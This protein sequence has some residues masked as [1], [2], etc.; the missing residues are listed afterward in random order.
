MDEKKQFELNIVGKVMIGA[1]GPE[2]KIHEDFVPAMKY[3]SMFSHAI[4]LFN[5]GC[6]APFKAL[7]S[8]QAHV[9]E[10]SGIIRLDR[11]CSLEEGNIIYDIKPYMPCEDRLLDSYA[12]S[13]A[14][15]DTA[16]ANGGYEKASVPP[17]GMVRR[18]QG[19]YYLYP[20][21]FD[22]TAKTIL[23][24]SHIKV[25][26]WFSRFDKPEFRRSTQG[27]PPYENAPR[28]GVFAT[29]SPVRPN[30]IAL[31]MARVLDIDRENR[32]IEVSE[33][34][35]FDKSPLIGVKPYIARSDKIE[36][37]TVPTWL[38]HWPDHNKTNSRVMNGPVQISDDNSILLDKYLP[39]GLG[40]D[41]G[42]FFN[43][44]SVQPRSHDRITVCGARQNNLKNIHVVIPKGKLTAVAGVSGS[45]KS[46]LAFDTLYAES[47]LRISETSDGMEKPEV[48][49]ITGLPP[50]VAIAQ[51]SIGRNPRSTVGTFTGIGDRLRLLYASVGQRHCPECGKPVQPRSRDEL[52]EI[53]KSLSDHA[54][55]VYPYNSEKAIFTNETGGEPAW[56]KIVDS[57]LDAGKGAFTIIIDSKDEI[58]LQTR[59]IC[60]CCG[61][62]LFKMTPA[63]FSFNNPESMCPVC[64]GLGKTVAIDPALV[65]ARPHVSLL[66]GASDYWGDMRVFSK[67]PTAN[68]MRGELLA[69]AESRMIDLELPWN[70]LPEEFRN[71]ALYGNNG[72]E[73]SWNYVHPKNG[74][75]G[76]IKRPVAGAIPTLTRLQQK[77][78][79]S[80]DRVA[81][82]FMRQLPCPAC[83]GERLSPEG[84][85]VTLGG[86]RF[87]QAAAMTVQE[88]SDWIQELPGKLNAHLAGVGRSMILDIYKKIQQLQSIGLAYLSLDRSIPTLSGGEIQ[89]L[90]LVAQ[91]GLG[92][93][94]M[95]YVMDEPTAGL[96]PRDYPSILQAMREL[97]EEGNTVLMV[98]HEEAL[99]RGVDHL[100]EIG[101]GAGQYGG[102]VVWQGKPEDI[103]YADTQTGQFLS[104]R[105][106]IKREPRPM[107]EHWVQISGAKGNNLQSIDVM[108][109]KG[110]ITCVT[111]VSGSGKSTLTSEVIASAIE[112]LIAKRP[113][114]PYCDTISG[115]EDFR[116]IVY[117]SQ[118][119]IGRSSRSSLSTYMGLWDE[120]RPLFS[121]TK[122]AMDAGFTASAF[123]FNSKEGQCDACKGEGWQVTAVPF[124]ADIR[125]TCPVCG[126]KRFKKDVL[127]VLYE[128][129]N[130][131]DVLELSVTQA[132]VFFAGLDKITGILQVLSEVG[133]GYLKL[134]QSA[135]TFSGGEAQRVK[136]AKALTG[137]QSGKVLYILDEPTSGLHFSDIQNLLALLDRLAARGH[138]LLLVEHTLDVIRNADWIIDLGP[139][140]GNAGGR[141][142]I[143]GTPE[144]VRNCS[145]SYTGRLI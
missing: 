39:G 84:R 99:L 136:L 3:L 51:G 108:F 92:L 102:E 4:F 73:V 45:G 49:S 111:G 137:K 23:D 69:L 138:T 33:L 126:G 56:T 130:V 58:L 38:A 15:A 75:S 120:I 74:R 83:H 25:F 17:C 1:N 127:S 44:P 87:P 6:T 13:D 91:M 14:M 81:Q 62:I 112:N 11:D 88:L 118:V 115:A 55:E 43:V 141:V 82:Q 107:A 77:G 21:S 48:D 119:P 63:L 53:M 67:N 89:R 93:S 16:C 96:H 76:T 34:D 143:Q 59:H 64:N 28:S 131:F 95:L 134:G 104:G 106:R 145:D 122:Q 68:W 109:P 40:F 142:V 47:R 70:E 2:I 124:G 103:T 101:P 24:C 132:L 46:S 31:T 35:C 116:S 117:A 78:G 79:G 128:E 32:R 71:T 41:N 144:T 54:L 139:E 97:R 125:A 114:G 18:E 129:K 105:Q 9:D 36:N 19:R 100:I 90:K 121:G 29:R 66:D 60:Y 123:S 27:D 94:G 20:D 140:G 133:L 7:V 50:A 113:A 86:V 65:V 110:R 52:T 12:P 26:W 42:S 85:M 8:A 22:E 80:A 98:E 61:H 72:E 30:P 10:R 57:A 5:D 37:A 135:V